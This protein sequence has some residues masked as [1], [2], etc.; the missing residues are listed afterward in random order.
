MPSWDYHGGKTDS[1]WGGTNPATAVTLSAAT[2]VGLRCIP[3]VDMWLYGFRSCVVTPGFA[4]QQRA[5]LWR[6]DGTGINQPTISF[7]HAFTPTVDWWQAWIRP[8]FKM[9]AGVEYRFAVLNF[10]S[11]GRT[12]SALVSPVTHNQM[13]FVQSFQSTAS[14]VETASLTMNNNANGSDL[15]FSPA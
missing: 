8:R 1:W 7:N 14:M 11:Y 13:Q 6:A 9:T 5:T 15:L 4:N 12:N 3:Q 10:S 2:W